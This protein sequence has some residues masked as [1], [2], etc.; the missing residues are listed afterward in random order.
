M[1]TRAVTALPLAMMLA[2]VAAPAAAQRLP[3]GVAPRH[4]DLTFTVDLAHARFE[5]TETIRLRIDAATPSIVLNALDIEFHEVTIGAGAGAQK[6]AVSLNGHDQTATLTV[7]KALAR[8][9][10]EVHIRYSG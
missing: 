10:T 6:A 9:A 4:Y 3:P 5:G 2:A 7:P 1:R 8:G